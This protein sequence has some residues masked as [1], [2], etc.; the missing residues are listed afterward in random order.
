MCPTH[1]ASF[2]SKVADFVLSCYVSTFIWC[3]VMQSLEGARSKA[4]D[5]VTLKHTSALLL[6]LGRL[7][8]GAPSTVV[9]AELSQ[10]LPW[11]LAA[12]GGDAMVDGD[13]EVATAPLLTL[14]EALIDP[15]GTLLHY[16]N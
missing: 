9:R 10:L 6:C 7:I 4:G 12:L 1:D 3:L 13:A 16:P 2:K 14:S 15:T 8:R 5:S 11:V